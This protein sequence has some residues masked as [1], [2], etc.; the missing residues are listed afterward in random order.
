MNNSDMN[1]VCL[2]CGFNEL[3]EPPYDEDGDPSYE[4]C[5]CCGFQFGFDDCD[6]GHTFVKYR[7]KWL[8]E[9]G[10]WFINESKPAEWSLEEQLKNIE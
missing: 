7:K 6:Q 9:G 5:P 8:E 1:F 4:I 10:V 2:V 3:L